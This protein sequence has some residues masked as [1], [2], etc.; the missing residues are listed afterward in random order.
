MVEV[1]PAVA[2]GGKSGR[3]GLAEKGHKDTFWG[4]GNVL[5]I[6]QC[7]GYTRLTFVNNQMGSFISCNLLPQY[8]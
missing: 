6:E 7:G 4:D 1:P 5:Y 8:I 2:W 3:G